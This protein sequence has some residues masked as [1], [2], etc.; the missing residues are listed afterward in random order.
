M[1]S[2]FCWKCGAD[3]GELPMPLARLAQCKSCHAFL[4]V[5]RQCDFYDT[6]V[7]HQCREPVA[8]E[9]KD[10]QRSNFCG[11]F[12]A[13]PDAFRPASEGA[14]RGAA[15]ELDALFGLTPGST[16]GATDS[17]DEARRKLDALFGD[18]KK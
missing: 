12:R 3:F 13:R 17:A 11:Y 18:S 16:S 5:C 9:V 7:A 1:T 6:S 8:E 2:F 4:H 14:A 10:K 15:S